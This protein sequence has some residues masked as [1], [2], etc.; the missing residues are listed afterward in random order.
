VKCAAIIGM[1]VV[2][3]AYFSGSDIIYSGCH[4]IIIHV[5][6]RTLTLQHNSV[7]IFPEEVFLFLLS[8]FGTCE[9]KSVMYQNV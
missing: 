6:F 9:C 3:T 4:N 2:M 1:H 7:F 5:T 8:P